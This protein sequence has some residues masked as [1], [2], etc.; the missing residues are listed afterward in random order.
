MT[1]IAVDVAREPACEQ[2]SLF[3]LPARERPAAVRPALA[4]YK[5]RLRPRVYP[6]AAG[7][8][9]PVRSASLPRRFVNGSIRRPKAAEKASSTKDT[10]KLINI[11]AQQER[12]ST[13]EAKWLAWTVR[14]G[15]RSRIS[16]LNATH[17]QCIA[18]GVHCRQ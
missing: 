8:G 5:G 13:A 9:V 12:P 14:S 6:E 11:A 15:L 1:Y 17:T 4:A 10:G 7:S 16:K 18:S 2:R 3:A